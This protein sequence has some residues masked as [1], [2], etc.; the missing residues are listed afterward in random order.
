MKSLFLF[1]VLVFVLL[2]TDSFSDLHFHIIT[3]FDWFLYTL[4]RRF[5]PTLHVRYLLTNLMRLPPTLLLGFLPA[6][7]FWL[8]AAFFTRFIPT[9][10][11]RLLPTSLVRLLPTSLMRSFLTPSLGFIP[12]FFVFSTFLNCNLPTLRFVIFLGFVIQQ[13]LEDFDATFPPDFEVTISF[14]VDQIQNFFRTH[15]F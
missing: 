3:V 15:G 13:F 11:P 6:N 14:C 2:I 8:L 7:L 9:L 1:L 10:L 4:P 5:L 12:A